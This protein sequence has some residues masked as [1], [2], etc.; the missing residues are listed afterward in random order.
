MCEMC[1]SKPFGLCPCG[2]GRAQGKNGCVAHAKS[3]GRLCEKHPVPGR[4][5]CRMHGGTQKRG[6]AHHA[7]KHGRFSKSIP[8]RLAAVAQDELHS[9]YAGSN[10]RE[11]ALMGARADELLGQLSNGGSSKA[12]QAV[13]RSLPKLKKAFYQGD[14]QGCAEMMGALEAAIE[15]G[16]GERAIW[17]E[18]LMVWK[19]RRDAI[20]SDNRNAHRR[21]MA[22]SLDEMRHILG[23][24]LLVMREFIPDRER[25]AE[26][27]RKLERRLPVAYLPES[28][29]GEGEDEVN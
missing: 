13:K 7:F 24:I 17:A 9:P 6:V 29:R 12:W 21:A 20:E 11:A 14:M 28:R 19:E 26:F 23:I 10:R 27:A 18:L 5:V 15:E 1:E 3:T 16:A 8:E 4:H 25:L 22:I 2:C